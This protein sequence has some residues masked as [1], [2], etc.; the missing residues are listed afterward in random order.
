ML[1]LS[2]STCKWNC[3]L[4]L[5][6][7]KNFGT[8]HDLTSFSEKAVWADQINYKVEMVCRHSHFFMVGH[9]H[10]ACFVW[11]SLWHNYEGCFLIMFYLQGILVV[12]RVDSTFRFHV[13]IELNKNLWQANLRCW[14]LNFLGCV[15]TMMY[16]G[17]MLTP[18]RK[19]FVV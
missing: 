10:R 6:K 3:S 11:V 15:L 4:A 19:Q 14:S 2:A 18:F 16:R 5:S 13:T 9:Y 17:E 7:R 12:R 8:L 1:F